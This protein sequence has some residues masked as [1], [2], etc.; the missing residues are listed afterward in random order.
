MNAG[1]LVGEVTW[2]VCFLSCS[3]DLTLFKNFCCYQYLTITGLAG[4]PFC[5]WLWF[6]FN[7]NFSKERNIH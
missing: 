7:N 2:M 6:L 5:F 4:I 1:H 3:E